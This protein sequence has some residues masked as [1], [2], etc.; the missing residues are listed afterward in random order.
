MTKTLH[1]IPHELFTEDDFGVAETDR[2]VCCRFRLEQ[3]FPKIQGAK[4]VNLTLSSAPL[5]GGKAAIF[6]SDGV[7]IYDHEEISL[8][9]YMRTTLSTIVKA[10][11]TI[12]FRACV[13]K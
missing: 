10:G 4:K 8:F 1:L 11:E 5:K 2:V 9:K 13:R 3:M 12:Y 7:L 6:A